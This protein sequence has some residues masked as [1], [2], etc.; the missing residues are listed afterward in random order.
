[1]YRH[2]S[3]GCQKI[4]FRYMYVLSTLCRWDKAQRARGKKER[5]LILILLENEII[6][7]STAVIWLLCLIKQGSHVRLYDFVFPC[8]S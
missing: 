8:Q 1:M 6:F 3:A 7:L 4:C 2:G 5:L